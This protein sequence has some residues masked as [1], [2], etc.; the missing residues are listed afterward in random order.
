MSQRVV[1][2][3][4]SHPSRRTLYI[5][6]ALLL[7]AFAIRVWTLSTSSVWW[8]EAFTWQTTSHG[9]DNLWH[10]LQTGDRNPPLYFLSLMVWGSVAGWS[11]FSLRFLS[12]IYGLLGVACL[13]RLAQRLFGSTA[14]LWTLALAALSPALT[15]YSQEGRAY[16]LFFACAM[17]TV[18]FGFL[19][20][21][22]GLNHRAWRAFLIAEILLLLTHYFAVPIVL[23]INV[24]I[25]V[26]LWRQHAAWRMCLKWIAGQLLAALPLLIWTLLIFRTPGSL[27][28][29]AE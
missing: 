11:E 7:A 21:E 20:L 3:V 9:W 15:L 5:S 28:T 17:A 12:V 26:R 1:E 2:A 13:A 8:D 25:V 19:I 10:L 16:A 14:S 18:Y 27:T 24:L 4:N 29:A 22:F 23:A 6:L